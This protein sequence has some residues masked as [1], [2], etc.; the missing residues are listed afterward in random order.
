MD[1][2][3][4]ALRHIKPTGHGIEI[5]PGHN[6]IAPKKEG[7]NVHIIDH[8]SRE[9]LI[10]KYKDHHVDLANIEEVDFVWQGGSYPELVGKTKHYDWIIASHLIEHTPDL[11]GFLND[12]DSILKEDGVISL[13]IPDKRFCFDHY[14]PITGL[15]RIIDSHFWECTRHTPGTVAEYFLNVVSQS[16]KIAWNS[17]THGEHVFVH[18]IDDALQGIQSA[19]H[20]NTYLDVHAWCFVPHSF[21]LIIHDLHSLGLISLK[22]LDFYST[23]GCEFFVTLAQLRPPSPRESGFQAEFLNDFKGP[24]SDS[25]M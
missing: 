11:I 4:K 16:G 3:Q 9:E 14:R 8:M 15:S 7:Y 10:A 13:V 18:S 21:R 17:H 22:E 2:K 20:G 19:L 5:G 6:P 24:R 1:R 23:D 25:A 12:C